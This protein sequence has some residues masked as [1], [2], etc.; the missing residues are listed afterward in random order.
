MKNYL[1]MKRLIHNAAQREYYRKN[2]KKYN[3]AT[4]KWRLE[5]PGYHYP[6]T[7]K[8]REAHRLW[9]LAHPEVRYEDRKR[10]YN[11]NRPKGNP[12]YRRWSKNEITAIMN[13][14]SGTDAELAIKLN[15]SILAIQLKRCKLGGLSKPKNLFYVQ[16]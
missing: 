15:R 8:Q 5:H 3:A 12:T 1:E 13:P 4:R 9:L 2:K 6:Y 14:R 10:Y 7:E 16:R 11:Q